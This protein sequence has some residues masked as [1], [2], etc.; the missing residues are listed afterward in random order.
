M[1]KRMH[2]V[3]NANAVEEQTAPF[4]PTA[5]DVYVPNITKKKMEFAFVIIEDCNKPNACPVTTKCVDREGGGYE[6][7][8]EEG[9]TPIFDKYTGLQDPNKYGCREICLPDDCN[10]GKCNIIG[11]TY[12]CICD[13]GYSGKYCDMKVLKIPGNSALIAGF[14]A[15]MLILGALLFALGC[16]LFRYFKNVKSAST[17]GNQQQENMRHF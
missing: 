10:A 1:A 13:E 16:I 5:S 14:S 4:I 6:C 11:N 3:K 7:V 8:C 2:I 17:Y 9:F 12:E 15:T